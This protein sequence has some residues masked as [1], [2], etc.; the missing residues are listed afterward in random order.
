MHCRRDTHYLLQEQIARGQQ[1]IK[2][3]QSFADADQQAASPV[4]YRGRAAAV[5]D[6]NRRRFLLFVFG[7]TEIVHRRGDLADL[8]GGPEECLDSQF[9]LRQMV[10]GFFRPGHG[11]TAQVGNPNSHSRHKTE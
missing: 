8:R 2:Q 3:H 9:E 7:R 10:G 11:R 4:D 1:Q 6:L 5:C